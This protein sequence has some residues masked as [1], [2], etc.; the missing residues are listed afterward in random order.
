MIRFE[1]AALPRV[2][3]VLREVPSYRAPIVMPGTLVRL[4]QTTIYRWIRRAKR[5][6]E[7]LAYERGLYTSGIV[8]S[9]ALGHDDPEFVGYQPSNWFV[10]RRMLRGRTVG[11]ADTFLD[12]GSGKGRVLVAASRY[13]FG[14]VIGIEINDGLNRI[15]RVNLESARCKRRC[16]DVEVITADV[17]DWAISDDVNYVYLF[18]PFGGLSFHRFLANLVDSLDRNPR[19]VTIIY[20]NPTLADA[21]ERTGRFR[22]VKVLKNRLR[23]DEVPSMWANVYESIPAV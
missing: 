7:Y 23:P 8:D 19:A 6:A 1:T 22:L 21:I 2:R 18:N 4:K 14:R 16:G 12:V 10:V 13:P 11:P 15:A 9:E 3:R 5:R 20:L 17:R